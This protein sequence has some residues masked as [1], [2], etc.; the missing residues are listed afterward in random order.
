MRSIGM[1]LGVIGFATAHAAISKTQQIFIQKTAKQFSLPAK[2]LRQDL[3]QAQ[4]LPLVIKKI[5]SPYEAKSWQFYRRHFLTA[6]RI[7]D[8]QDY[9]KKHRT[10]FQQAEQ[11]F[12]VPA[13]IIAAIIGTE[14]LYGKYKGSFMVLDALNTLAFHYPSRQRFFQKELANFLVYI[15]ENDFAPREIKGSYAGAIGLPQFMPSSIRHYAVSYQGKDINLNHDN[16]AIFSVAN[17]LAQHGWHKQQAVAI[18]VSNTTPAKASGKTYTL[19]HY[20]KMGLQFYSQEKNST[21]AKVM[22]FPSDPKAQRWLAL[23]NFQ[24]IRRYNTSDNYVMAVWQ[25]AE[26][27]NHKNARYYAALNHQ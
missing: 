25:L 13:N 27:I 23:P 8:G 10:V 14:T 18:P 19:Q 24:V 11:R 22:S 2:A 15:Q 4:Y 3:S 26:A 21:M 20:K 1:F 12:H 9:I 6:Q 16:D 17:Y 7:K 5:S